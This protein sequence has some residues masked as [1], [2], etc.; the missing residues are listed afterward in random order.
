[1]LIAKEIDERMKKRIKHRELKRE[2]SYQYLI[3]L[4]CYKVVKHL[5]GEKEYEPFKI[6]W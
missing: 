6:W 5:I 4:E 1:M 3:R 2:V